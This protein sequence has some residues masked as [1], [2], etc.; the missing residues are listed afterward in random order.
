[1]MNQEFFEQLDARI[2]KYDLLCHP[3]YKAWTAGEL[4]RDDL[5]EYALDYYHHV[6]AFPLYLAALAIRLEEGG[7]RRAVLA[8]MCEEN[9]STD[10]SGI[11]DRSHAKLWLDFAEGM[12]ATRD[13]GNQE[14]L[15]E[16]KDLIAFFSQVAGDR[17]PEEALAAFYVYESQ[18]PRV[19]AEKARGLRDR[20]GADESTCAY[21]TLH[22]TADVYHSRVWRQQ[23]GKL[24][25]ANP[26]AAEN[27]LEAGEN[28]ARVLWVALDGIEARRM[29]RAAAA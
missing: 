16:I 2:A 6:A 15:A 9:G 13:V 1:M 11:A 10:T 26:Q 8:N 19:A 21:F 22:T 23:L 28:A 14:P 18:V 3:F 20:Y 12:G 17:T 27:A 24:L 7:L 29:A 25:E 5:R 4:T